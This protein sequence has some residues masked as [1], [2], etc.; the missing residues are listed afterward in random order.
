[1]T[2]IL[3][4][5]ITGR[6]Y[7]LV[8]RQAHHFGSSLLIQREEKVVLRISGVVWR[9]CCCSLVVAVF[10]LLCF[11]CFVSCFIFPFISLQRERG[12]G[13]GG[14]CCGKGGWFGLRSNVYFLLIWDGSGG[15]TTYIL[16]QHFIS[17]IYFTMYS[18]QA[19]IMVNIH[20]KYQTY[21][22]NNGK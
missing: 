2:L 16:S 8:F 11:C 20:Y 15:T 17:S 19:L 14:Q 5:S 13:F 18:S 12:V 10:V 7:A 22:L 9:D 3:L 6:I 1:M 21:P 4:G